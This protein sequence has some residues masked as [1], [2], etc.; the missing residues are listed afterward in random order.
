M[1]S[2]FVTE[3]FAKYCMNEDLH[4]K[5]SVEIMMPQ[6]LLRVFS[7]VHSLLTFGLSHVHKD[8]GQIVI[9]SMEP[10]M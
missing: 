6:H 5:P 1:K 10:S 4:L 2:P 9:Y 3:E 7:I 8:D